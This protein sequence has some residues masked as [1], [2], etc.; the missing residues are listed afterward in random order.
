MSAQATTPYLVQYTVDPTGQMGSIHHLGVP[1]TDGMDDLSG[2][3]RT[4]DRLQQAI[5]SGV[6]DTADAATALASK[7]GQNITATVTVAITYDPE[8]PAIFYDFYHLPTVTYMDSDGNKIDVD[9]GPNFN[10][11]AQAARTGHYFAALSGT[12][13]DDDPLT[14]SPISHSFVGG[15]DTLTSAHGNAVNH[16]GETPLDIISSLEQTAEEVRS[17]NFDSLP[18]PS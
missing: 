7:Y 12:S 2:T 13:I 5:D 1:G 8:N 6:T 10:S 15:H 9:N 14:K 18:K 17:M 11:P 4:N 3:L 16:T